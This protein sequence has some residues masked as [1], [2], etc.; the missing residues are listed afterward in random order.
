MA[1]YDCN[2]R[3]NQKNYECHDLYI[4]FVQ[5]ITGTYPISLEFSTHKGKNILVYIH[6]SLGLATKRTIRLVCVCVSLV[7]TQSTNILFC[8]RSRSK[9]QIFSWSAQHQQAYH[10]KYSMHIW[11]CEIVER[12]S[13]TAKENISENCLGHIVSHYYLWFCE[14]FVPNHGKNYVRIRLSNERNRAN[15]I[16]KFFN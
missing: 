15:A 9:Q 11:E 2:K 16:T 1:R 5:A 12:H 6:I 4:N 8:S 10:T 7:Y 13:K 14:N 3:Q